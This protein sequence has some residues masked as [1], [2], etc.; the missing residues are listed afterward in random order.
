MNAENITRVIIFLNVKKKHN[1]A[2]SRL[3]FQEGP[4][5]LVDSVNAAHKGGLSRNHS[6]VGGVGGVC[7]E[8][9]AEMKN[10]QATRKSCRSVRLEHFLCRFPPANDPTAATAETPSSTT[11]RLVNTTPSTPSKQREGTK[12]IYPLN[13]ETSCFEMEIPHSSM[14]IEPKTGVIAVDR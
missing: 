11:H 4:N 14:I 2:T 5:C 9:G 12:G 10:N 8:G 7:V 3:R 1:A 6:K 13:R